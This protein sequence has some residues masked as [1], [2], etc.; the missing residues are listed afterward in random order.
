MV[1]TKPPPLCYSHTHLG[2]IYSCPLLQPRHYLQPPMLVCPV[3]SAPTYFAVWHVRMGEKK[4]TWTTSRNGVECGRLNMDNG[5][6]R[7]ELNNMWSNLQLCTWILKPHFNYYTLRHETHK[8]CARM[9]SLQ[10]LL[11]HVLPY[12]QCTSYVHIEG[13][14][15]SLL[16][17]LYTN[18][19]K[20]YE[21]WWDTFLLIAGKNNRNQIRI[22]TGILFGKFRVMVCENKMLSSANLD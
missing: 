8:Q 15:N 6:L 17:N 20:W 18:I 5:K 14:Y 9:C 4:R 3:V 13:T 7:D 16:R 2:H 19:Q 11:S 1:N 10:N 22:K 21:I 12:K